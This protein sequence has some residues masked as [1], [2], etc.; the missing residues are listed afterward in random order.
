MRRLRHPNVVLFMGAVTRPPNLSI[1]SEFLPRLDMLTFSPLY[2]NCC[3]RLKAL[4][5]NSL[6][7]TI[8]NNSR[9]YRHGH[10]ICPFPRE[11]R[12]VSLDVVLEVLSMPTFIFILFLFSWKVLINVL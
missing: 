1:V 3:W 4:L 12:N 5:S 7:F 11:M 8:H 9:C 10:L 2:K 6:S